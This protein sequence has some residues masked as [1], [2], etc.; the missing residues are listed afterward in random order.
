[1]NNNNG[2]S[3]RSIKKKERS[4]P[5]QRWLVEYNWMRFEEIDGEIVMF[6][7][8][9][10]LARYNNIFT[11]GS[12]NYRIQSV[13]QHPT[14]NDHQRAICNVSRK[15]SITNHFKTVLFM[16]KNCLGIENYNSFYEFLSQPTRDIN[17]ILSDPNYRQPYDIFQPTNTTWAYIK[18]NL[19][20]VIQEHLLHE[21]SQLNYFTLRI[22]ELDL[23]NKKFLFVTS[24]Y[25][26]SYTPVTRYIGFIE[27][28][29]DVFEEVKKFLFDKILNLS[30]IYY[31]QT[32][33]EIFKNNSK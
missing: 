13:K 21:M 12:K 32:S 5:D 33:G 29:I 24:H 4:Q 26:I 1:M 16:V 23:V 22:E 18:E 6:C 3:S 19:A 31:L 2:N 10:E 7:K 11:R 25:T 27:I 17:L 30:R 15:T 28:T 9:C 20:N 14:I 8:L